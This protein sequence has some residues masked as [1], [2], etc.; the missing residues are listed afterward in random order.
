MATLTPTYDAVDC[1]ANVATSIA[2][3]SNGDT[4]RFRSAA[5]GGGDTWNFK[6]FTEAGAELTVDA[7][8]A[9]EVTK[10]LTLLLDPGVILQESAVTPFT[11]SGADPNYS[12]QCL[13]RFKGRTGCGITFGAGSKL[14]GQKAAHAGDHSEMMCGVRFLGCTNVSIVGTGEVHFDSFYG[15]GLWFASGGNVSVATNT[16]VSVTDCKFSNNY[17]HGVAIEDV[18]GFSMKRCGGESN[19]GTSSSCW[20][21]VEPDN[22]TDSLVNVLIDGADFKGHA[23]GLLVNLNSLDSTSPTISLVAR[24]C[25]CRLSTTGGDDPDAFTI[26]NDL[27]TASKPPGTLE[28]IDCEGFNINAS[29]FNIRWDLA[30]GA[31]LLK[32]IRC[33]SNNCATDNSLYKPFKFTLT[34]TPAAA[35]GIRMNDCFAVEQKHANRKCT[36][37]TSA[38]GT[39]TNVIGSIRVTGPF[40]ST[41]GSQAQSLLPNLRIGSFGRP[42]F[43]NKAQARNSANRGAF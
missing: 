9:I 38:D 36:E 27:T 6:G 3:A 21:D 31:A 20:C 26:R 11:A 24:N 19:S 14:L 17:R 18:S 35:T 4:I 5:N 39:A 8:G 22:T 1:R 40:N 25:R 32:M 13:I 15:D 37:V 41:F 42:R 12:R 29:A 34:G 23:H 10:N 7:S 33:G 30:T 16:T 43:T 2:A 28:F